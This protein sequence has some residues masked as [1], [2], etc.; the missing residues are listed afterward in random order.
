M[1]HHT[2]SRRNLKLCLMALALSASCATWADELLPWY[3]GASGGPTQGAI[4]DARIL[5]H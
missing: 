4:D 5:Q 1:N 2:S 3:V